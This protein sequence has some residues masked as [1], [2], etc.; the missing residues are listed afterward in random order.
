MSAQIMKKTLIAIFEDDTVNR[1][2]YEKMFSGRKDISLFVFDQV[3][4]GLSKLRE[5]VFDL[6][7]IEAH[8]RQNFGGVTILQRMKATVNKMPVCIAITSLLQKN[9]L[10]TLMAAGFTMCLEK[11]INFNEVLGKGAE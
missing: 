4:P 9:D 8:F 3:E 5:E 6:V 11:P 7:F 10:E 2:I 1:Y